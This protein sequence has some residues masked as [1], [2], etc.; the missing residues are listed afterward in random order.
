MS[1]FR[2]AAAPAVAPRSAAKRAPS[3]RPAQS[4]APGSAP[5]PTPRT[6]EPGER[7]SKRVMQL[8]NCSRSQAEHYIE[9]DWVMVNGVVVQDPAFRVQQQVVT[10]APDASL[11][12][13]GA[14]TLIL[15]KPADCLDGLQ[16]DARADRQLR[17]KPV[18]RHQATA[19]VS[20][21]ARNLLTPAAH[22]AQD[23]SGIRPLKR[24]LLQLQADVPLETGASGLLV[25]TQDWRTTRKLREDLAAMEHEF[26]VDVAGQLSPEALHGMARALSDGR[27]PLPATKVSINSSTPD[28]SKLRFA[29][30]GAHPGLVAYLCELA[31]LQIQAMRRIRLG[32]VALADLPLGQ[33]RYLGAHEKF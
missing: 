28:L 27:N 25:F 11:L 5:R 4:P 14:V 17:Q 15:N 16:A 31:G 6:P 7:L 3:H 21:N 24:H 33:W 29:I 32:R 23:S 13:L 1:T 12:D 26:I 9:G 20:A 10:L 30:K 2:R 18:G 22:F 8:K 19:P